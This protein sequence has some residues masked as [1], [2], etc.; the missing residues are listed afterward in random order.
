[1]TSNGHD[2]DLLRTCTRVCHGRAGAGLQIA[3]IHWDGQQPLMRWRTVRRWPRR[4]SAAQALRARR[5]ALDDRRF[6]RHCPRCGKRHALGHMMD[7]QPGSWCQGCA[8]QEGVV[9]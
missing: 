2:D 8:Q 5:Q 4:P 6:F 3:S 9:F 1:M 7:S